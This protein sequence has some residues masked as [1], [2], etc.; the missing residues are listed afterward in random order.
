MSEESSKAAPRSV[1]SADD[2]CGQ[3][4]D[5][6]RRIRAAAMTAAIWHMAEVSASHGE[7]SQKEGQ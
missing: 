3:L 1:W 4:H 6:S 2:L 5:V 7:L